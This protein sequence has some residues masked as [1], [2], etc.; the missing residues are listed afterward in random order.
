LI[1]AIK[2]KTTFPTESEAERILSGLRWIGV[3]G[4]EKVVAR[5]SILDTLCATLEQKMA[6]GKGERDMVML[7]HKFEIQLKDGTKVCLNRY[8][9]FTDIE[10]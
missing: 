4:Q 6:Y 7:Q 8:L 2:A 1:E 5:Q 3:F 10:C 9:N